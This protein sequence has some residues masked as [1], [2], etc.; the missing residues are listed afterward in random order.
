MLEDIERGGH[1]YTYV[2]LLWWNIFKIQE[3]VVRG[4][5][6]RALSLLYSVIPLLPSMLIDSC[7]KMLETALE[8]VRRRCS[9]DCEEYPDSMIRNWCQKECVK[10]ELRKELRNILKHMSVELEKLGYKRYL[11]KPT[12]V[13]GEGIGTPEIDEDM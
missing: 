3:S 9:S 10:T 11:G 4:D 8:D 1:I 6:R 2:D 5:V 7:D 12:P 13:G